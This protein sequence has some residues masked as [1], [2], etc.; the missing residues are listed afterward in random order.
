MNEITD[1]TESA[2]ILDSLLKNVSEN[3][4]FEMQWLDLLSQMEF[5]GLRKIV[6][7]VPYEKMD[8]STLQHIYEEAG[9]AFLL[10][11]IL[12]REFGYEK[13]W[14]ENPLSPFG[15]EYF[16]ELDASI[17]LAVKGE[18]VSYPVV[19]WVVEERALQVYEAYLK[20]S[21]HAAIR[22]VLKRILAQEK[23]HSENFSFTQ[24][25]KECAQI[26]PRLWRRLT[27]QILRHWEKGSEHKTGFEKEFALNHSSST[28]H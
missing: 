25:S 14:T 20:T 28:L 12:L 21:P 17:S 7:A 16:K 5:I 27:R 10:K 24:V 23:K 6:K 13:S 4:S 22:A 8:Q 19:S 11:N 2:L 15:W 1:S 3:P 18:Q 26:E 9:H